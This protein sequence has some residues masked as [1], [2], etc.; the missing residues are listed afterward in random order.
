M[1]S[2]FKRDIGGIEKEVEMRPSVL[3]PFD[4]VEVF[5]TV[6]ISSIKE[7][8]DELADCSFFSH[9]EK[10]R[11]RRGEQIRIYCEGPHLKVFEA[12]QNLDQPVTELQ[13]LGQAAFRAE[14]ALAATGTDH[15]FGRPSG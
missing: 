9:M 15:D 2:D 4:D 11:K 8:T 6:Q 5:A 3:V 14:E 7:P 12:L 1:A 10:R 13:A